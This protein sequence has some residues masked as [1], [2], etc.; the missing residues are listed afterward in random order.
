MNRKRTVHKLS[1]II[2]L[3]NH[4]TANLTGKHSVRIRYDYDGLKNSQEFTVLNKDISRE[5]ADRIII[6]LK[7]NVKSEDI[8]YGL[9]TN[10]L[11]VRNFDY[12]NS[13]I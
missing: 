12:H 4:D 6:W 11:D 8:I 13:N 10:S 2:D 7:D 1:T 9:E 3:L 5:S